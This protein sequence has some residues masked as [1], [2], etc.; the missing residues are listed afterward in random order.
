MKILA[1]KKE[2]R[3]CEKC[4]FFVRFLEKKNTSFDGECRRYPPDT[5][6]GDRRMF[7]EVFSF[8]WCGEWRDK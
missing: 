6:L 3:K 5:L 7:R 8:D 2:P 1:A 4:I